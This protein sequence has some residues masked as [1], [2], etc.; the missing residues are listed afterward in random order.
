MQKFN[1]DKYHNMLFN[2]I[3]VPISYHLFYVKN[4]HSLLAFFQAYRSLVEH[5]IFA[6]SLH[7]IH[8]L[9]Y[10]PH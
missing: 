3:K 7:T 6:V 9:A 8:P 5:L 1:Y 10:F 4:A 2:I